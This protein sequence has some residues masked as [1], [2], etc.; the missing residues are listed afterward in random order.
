MF[1]LVAQGSYPPFP[2]AQFIQ[3]IRVKAILMVTREKTVKNL[4]FLAATM[5]S[6]AVSLRLRCERNNR[7]VAMPF[8][9]QSRD[10]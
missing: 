5:S 1:G 4:Q 2:L 3:I 7:A 10:K 8:P 9:H 6:G